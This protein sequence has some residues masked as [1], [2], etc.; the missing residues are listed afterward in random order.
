MKIA[1]AGGAGFIGSHLTRAYLD[2]GHDVLVLDT[3][4]SGMRQ[5]VDARARFYRVD[6]RDEK[7]GRILQQERPDVVS[8][9]VAQHYDFPY[10]H[11]LTDADVHIRG[12]LNILLA[13]ANASVG[14]FIFASGGNR[15]YGHTAVE[16]FPLPEETPLC[17]RSSHDIARAAG[18]WYVRYYTQQYGLKHTI[19]RYAD[20][21]GE[22][23]TTHPAHLHHPI[24]YF[25]SMLAEQRSP[26]I[27]SNGDELNDH[28]FIDDVVNAN[29]C[30]LKRGQNQTLHISSA[31]GYTLS[32]IFQMVAYCLQSK[33]E[34]V[35]LSS[36]TIET[37]A[38]LDNARACRIL[39]WSPQ[40]GMAEGIRRALALLRPQTVQPDHEQLS[41]QISDGDLADLSAATLTAV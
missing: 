18:E 39:D 15:M 32:Q 34:P 8:Y 36:P 21:Y 41:I 3:L 4:F 31:R 24:S 19:L 29:L 20:V 2:A 13:C 37:S 12:L 11:S 22:R 33:L 35:Y 27:R 17:P 30:A 9:H 14:K 38:V 1:I 6:I 7:L 16:Q 28:I 10:E 40:I 26:I 23:E 5:A 25:I